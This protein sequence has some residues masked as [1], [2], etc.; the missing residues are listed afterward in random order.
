M[1][2]VIWIFLIGLYLQ[3]YL[4]I[5]EPLLPQHIAV[6]ILLRSFIIVLGWVFIIG[7]L[8]RQLLHSWLKKEQTG[9]QTEMAAVLNLLPS[10]EQLVIASWRKASGSSGLRKYS[11]TFKN[12]LANALMDERPLI[13]ILTASI[14]SGKTT[15]ILNWA[16]ER[17]QVYGVLSPVLNGKRIFL[18]IEN[19]Q[20]YPMEAEEADTD[21][22]KVG[23][24]VFSKA[25]FDKASEI[26]LAAVSKEGWL[27]IDEVGPLELGGQGLA[28]AVRVI[29]NNRKGNT[30]LV[31]REGLAEKVIDFCQAP[32]I[33]IKDISE[34]PAV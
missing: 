6:G 23:R 22:L 30:L 19:L 29:I 13:Y 2:F 32:A 21:V 33:I 25:S 7:P 16:K 26:I 18:D 27:V 11:E 3:S 14:G 10:T 24:F 15:S 9:A 28:A 31:V 17:E 34:L 4:G 20:E 5:G 1:L 12:I 8:L